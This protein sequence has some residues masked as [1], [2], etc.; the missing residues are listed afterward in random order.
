MRVGAHHSPFV[1]GRRVVEQVG[2][3]AVGQQ[4]IDLLECPLHHFVVRVGRQVQTQRGQP[5]QPV[6]DHVLSRD[7]Q[8]DDEPH[9]SRGLMKRWTYIIALH[10]GG[11]LVALNVDFVLF[12][13]VFG[14]L[15]HRAKELLCGFDVLAQVLALR[16]LFVCWQSVSP[17]VVGNWRPVYGLE[18][19]VPR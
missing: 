4:L 15:D 19:V 12:P 13:R 5:L 10:A 18:R 14:M 1:G 8:N 17:T 9:P 16:P 6:R 3:L 11:H 2:D 7:Y